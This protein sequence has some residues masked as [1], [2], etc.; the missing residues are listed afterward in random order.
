MKIVF[1]IFFIIL[2]TTL[3]AQQDAKKIIRDVNKKFAL[4]NDY[5]ADIKILFDL[6]SIK[7][8]QINGRVYFKKP[9]KFRIKGAGLFLLP[10][11]NP[12]ENISS[13]LLDTNSYTAVI[14][15][16]EVIEN[17]NCILINIIPLKNESDLVLGKFWVDASR[18]LILHSQI[19]T[20]KSGTLQTFSTYKTQERVG[21]PDKIKILLEMKAFK[22]PKMIA[23]DISKKSSMK[24]SNPNEVKNGTLELFFTDYKINTKLSD[25]EFID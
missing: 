19:T 12:L 23:V 2:S 22:V 15:G 10:K 20:K 9:N 4:V 25:L 5:N 11:Q 1:S 16:N 8:K 24:K 14:T 18:S 6:P 3:F 7:L 13:L 21:L 17:I